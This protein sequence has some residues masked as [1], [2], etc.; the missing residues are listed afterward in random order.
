MATK[1]TKPEVQPKPTV[2]HI[3]GKWRTVTE[4]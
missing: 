4:Q 2:R 3:G 1:K